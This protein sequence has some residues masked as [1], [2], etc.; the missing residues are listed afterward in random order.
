MLGGG[1]W[2]LGAQGHHRPSG[3][4]S[5]LPETLSQMTNKPNPQKAITDIAISNLTFVSFIRPSMLAQ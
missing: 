5:G 1:G 3:G 4:L 2:K